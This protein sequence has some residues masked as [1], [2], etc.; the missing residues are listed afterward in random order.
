MATKKIARTRKSQVVPARLIERRIYLVHGQQVMLDSDLAELYQVETRALIQAVKR[1]EVRFPEDFMFQ[2]T[3]DETECLRSQNVMSKVGRGGRR[4]SPYVFTQEGVAMLSSVL[5]SDRAIRV[6]IAIM[7]VFVKT[8]EVLANHKE[9]AAEMER[10][11]NVQSEQ[12]DQIRQVFEIV[13]EL[14]APVTDPKKRTI[15]FGR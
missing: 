9:L 11:K 13:E 3:P 14:L 4:T 15:G 8:R 5:T 6:H 1:N 7:R 10:L 12:G 2:L